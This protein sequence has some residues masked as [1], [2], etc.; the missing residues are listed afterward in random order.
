MDYAA[1][2][3]FSNLLASKVKDSKVAYKTRLA[4]SKNS[5]CFYRYIRDILG[6]SVRTPQL[7]NS[8]GPIITEN[9]DIANVFADSFAIND[10][11]IQPLDSPPDIATPQFGVSLYNVD[12]I[13]DEIRVKLQKL[14]ETK[15][16]GPDEISAAI[17]KK[18][19]SV[20]A[21]PLSLLMRQSLNSGQVPDESR[22]ATV[23]PIFKKC[24]KLDAGNYR[25]ICLTSTVGKVMECIISDGMMQFLIDNKVIPSEQHVFISDRSV[26]SNLLCRLNYYWSRELD[27][28]NLVDVVY[29]N[30]SKAFNKVTT[31][32][33]VHKLA[34]GGIRGLLRCIQGF[35]SHRTFRVKI[36]SFFS[37]QR[38]VLS[39]VPQ[40]SVFSRFCPSS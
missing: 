11:T 18:C 23:K 24:N 22:T 28:G 38:E 25:P 14:N 1:H 34:D 31:R 37:S 13:E 20:L 5:K 12:F 17:L 27:N 7:R 9:E 32:R 26:S 10:F 36:S 16:P 21:R 4:S 33:L 39:E 2:R 19:A 35:L 30:F 40:G 3:A 6:G 8:A 15:S 29:N